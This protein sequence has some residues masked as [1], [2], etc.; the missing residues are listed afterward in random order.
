MIRSRLA[1]SEG[2]APAAWPGCVNYRDIYA[3]QSQGTSQKVRPEGR[4]RVQVSPSQV[5][6]PTTK[7]PEHAHT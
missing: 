6:E 5:P 3:G 1:G 4:S 2:D 7:A